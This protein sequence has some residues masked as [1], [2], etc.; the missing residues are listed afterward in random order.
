MRLKTGGVWVLLF[1]G[2]GR[3]REKTENIKFEWIKA[4][5]NC[6][7]IL[8]LFFKAAATFQLEK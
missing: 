6:N 8:P 7:W 1:F 3:I 5:C 4:V 2:F